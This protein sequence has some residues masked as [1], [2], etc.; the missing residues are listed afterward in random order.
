M[1]EELP[2]CTPTSRDALPAK[3]ALVSAKGCSSEAFT[4]SFAPFK[5]SNLGFTIQNRAWHVL[6]SSR[7]SGC[8]SEVLYSR[9]E[10]KKVLLDQIQRL[11]VIFLCCIPCH[12][13]ADD[14]G[15]I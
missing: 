2:I 3:L 9:H 15:V 1:D 11:R 10:A 7:R 14:R 8:C 6:E 12:G 13:L 5:H 4:S